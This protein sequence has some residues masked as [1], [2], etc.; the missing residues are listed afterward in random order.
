MRLIVV[1]MTSLI[2]PHTILSLCQELWISYSVDKTNFDTFY[3]ERNTIRNLIIPKYLKE[4]AISIT[5]FHNCWRKIYTKL[6][7]LIN[8]RKEKIWL[9]CF[10]NE[11]F[12]LWTY[13]YFTIETNIDIQILLKEF[14]ITWLSKHQINE[15]YN[16]FT[17][18]KNWH[19]YCRWWNFFQS[20]G[21][22]YAFYK[23]KDSIRSFSMKNSYSKNLFKKWLKFL[24]INLTELALTNILIV[25]IYFKLF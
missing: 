5:E 21:K 19:T 8:N 10:G 4:N 13:Y 9:H 15:L 16:L 3:T 23:K 6:S 22:S 25:S 12:C 20:F 14:W 7:S 2:R 17:N 1:F 11:F 24:V 18:N